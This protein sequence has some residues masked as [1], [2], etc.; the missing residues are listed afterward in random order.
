MTRLSEY[1]Q[2]LSP[3]RMTGSI[4]FFKI[5]KIMKV[6]FLNLKLVNSI[7]ADEIKAAVNRVID[8]GHYILGEEVEKFE[9]EFSKYCGVKYSIGVDNGLNALSL[10]LRALGIGEGD[11]V[12]VP[13]NTYIATALAV[14]HVG[15]I[16]VAVE[17]DPKTYNIDP[18]RIAQSITKKTKAI[19]PVH[20]Y[21]S[22]CDM[23]AIMEIAKKFNL[24]VVEDCAQS[25]GACDLNGKKAGSFGIAS[26][27]SF[28]PGK[29]LG[30]IGDGGCITTDDEKLAHKIKILRNYGSQKKYFNDEI[31]FN[32]RL[33]EVQAAILR[34]KLPY[35]DLDNNRRRKVALEYS[36]RIKNSKIILPNISQNQASHVWHLFVIRCEKRDELQKFL[37]QRG[38][39]SL[40]HYPKPFYKQ[41]CYQNL[42][43]KT[44]FSF[45]KIHDQILSLPIS[46]V[47]SES[48]IEQVVNALND[49]S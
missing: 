1:L 43:S 25:H 22:L 19:M 27:F 35:L 16:P 36:A 4:F 21:G 49:Y 44:E 46:G 41:P 3:R 17:S 6:E 2:K 33:D 32:S 13:S 31:G 14:S 26:G 20:L 7:H 39:T 30:A 9:E 34:V 38:I 29:N 18:A 12:L 11:E 48:E 42:F 10:I 8:S 28:Y 47:I 15:A 45:D 40:I 24:H 5:Y 23:E 37:E